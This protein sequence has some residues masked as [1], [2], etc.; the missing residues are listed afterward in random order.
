MFSTHPGLTVEQWKEVKEMLSRRSLLKSFH[1]KSFG[2]DI[3]KTAYS[4]FGDEIEGY[5]FDIGEWQDSHIETLLSSGIDKNVCRVGIEVQ[6]DEYTEEIA[7]KIRSAGFFASAWNVK[8]RDFSEYE[9]L[10]SYGVT[11]FTE[12][13]HASM[14]LNY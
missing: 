4:V 14:G 8:H 2:I 11:E 5:T 9:R 10:M 12:D 13:Y 3:L 7:E 6:F 1:I